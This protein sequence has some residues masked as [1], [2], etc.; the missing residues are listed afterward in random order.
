M[1]FLSN[2]G[3]AYLITKLTGIGFVVE[4]GT[5]FSPKIAATAFASMLSLNFVPVP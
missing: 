3:L 4:T 5:V 2:S 1:K